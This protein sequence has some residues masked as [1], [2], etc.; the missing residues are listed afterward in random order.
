MQWQAI[1]EAVQQRWQAV[2]GD[3]LLG[4][5][6]H[7][8]IA[9]GCFNPE[10]SDIDFLAVVE[11]APTLPQKREMIRCLTALADHAPEK[12]IE[13]SVLLR[14]DCEH[15]AHPTP[16]EMHYSAAWHESY[17][18]DMDGTLARLKGADADLAAHITVTRAVGIALKGP[19]PQEMFAPVPAED[20]LDSIRGDVEN[21]AE[22]VLR[23]PVYILLNLCRV[24]AYSRSGAVLSKAEG[25]EWGITR[26]P[27]KY[28]ALLTGALRSYR[29]GEPMATN[30]DI[31]QEFARYMLQ[32]ILPAEQKEAP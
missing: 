18:A 30:G 14:R 2:L 15:F 26:L 19:A 9:F 1:M 11:E 31:L 27:E 3:N 17:L 7:G 12:G 20:Y 16:Y 25:G 10:K 13:M 23:D 22:D 6:V 24:L 32:Q 28:R 4:I 29:T 5:Y 21:A 8:S